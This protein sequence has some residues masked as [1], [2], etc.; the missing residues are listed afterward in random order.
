MKNES[1]IDACLACFAVCEM[2]ATECIKLLK[3]DHL[4]CI[5]LCRDCADVCALCLKFEE[6]GSEFNHHIM[7]LCAD[8]CSAC[9]E[10][11]EKFA[12]QHSHCRECATACRECAKECMAY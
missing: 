8:V 5:A 9:A 12:G 4:R 1:M 7:R 3:E 11:C 10:E 2:C 6:R